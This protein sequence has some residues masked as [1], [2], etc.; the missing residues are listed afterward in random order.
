MVKLAIVTTH[1]I[2]NYTPIFKLLPQQ[3]DLKICVFYTWGEQSV[4]KY[5]PGFGKA[6]S[7]DIPLMDGYD[8]IFEKNTARKPG[9][10][11]FMGIQNPNH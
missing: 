10:H 6:I 2:Q 3:Q 8:F 9:S 7:W 11:H 1:P 4:S 5:D